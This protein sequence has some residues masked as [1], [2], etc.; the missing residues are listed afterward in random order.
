[1][2]KPLNSSPITPPS[3]CGFSRRKTLSNSD[4]LDH[5]FLC[6]QKL[7]P[8]KDIYMYKGD[9]AFCSV[10]CRWRQIFMD[11][12]ETV[13]KNRRDNCSLDAIKLRL[14]SSSSSSSSSSSATNRSGKGHRNGADAIAY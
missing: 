13:K 5:C 7:L 3:P 14:P 6:K 10:E 1:M 12:E 4:F 9:I 8:D 11:E 2:I